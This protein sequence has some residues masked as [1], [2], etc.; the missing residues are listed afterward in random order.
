MEYLDNFTSEWELSPPRR[1]P[2]DVGF[3]TLGGF[4]STTMGRIPPTGATF[5]HEGTKYTI[6]DAEP[7]KVNRVSIDLAMQPATE[8]H[9]EGDLGQRPNQ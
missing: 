2:D 8:Q 3:D 1:N 7:Q 9:G 4:I 6:L 5:E